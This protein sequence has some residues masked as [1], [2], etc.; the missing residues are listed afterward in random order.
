MTLSVEVDVVLPGFVTVFPGWNDRSGSRVGNQFQESI[1]IVTSVTDDISSLVA[2]KQC[3]SLGNVMT[4]T[5]CQQ[6]AKRIA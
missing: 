5:T 2:L 1:G 3:G 6:E 4:V